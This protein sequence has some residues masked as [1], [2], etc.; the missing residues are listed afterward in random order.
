MV[1]DTAPVYR[2][3]KTCTKNHGPAQPVH[4]FCRRRFIGLVS[5]ASALLL[6]LHPAPTATASGASDLKIW[7]DGQKPSFTLSDLS[8]TARD[9]QEFKG[10]VVLVHFFATWCAPCVEE[11]TSLRKLTEQMHGKPLKVV[12][13]NVAEVE[14]RVRAF[15]EK[16]PVN[17]PVLLDRDRAV[18]KAWEVYGLPSTFVLDADL[19]PRL[20]VEGDLDWPRPE[21]LKQLE[22]LY[23]AGQRA[24]G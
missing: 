8:G 23:P 21:I 24:G 9:L 17:F 10:N 3:F 14:L 19:T 6:S 22:A 4:T 5:F 20:F 2:G 16:L 18:T 1:F 13:V 11:M 12:A 7:S 15:F